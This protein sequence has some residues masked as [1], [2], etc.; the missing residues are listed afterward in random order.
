VASAPITYGGQ[1][2]K[3]KKLK[4]VVDSDDEGGSCCPW[5]RDWRCTRSTRLIT[6]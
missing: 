5:E 4:R 2:V 3:K 6:M 1:Q